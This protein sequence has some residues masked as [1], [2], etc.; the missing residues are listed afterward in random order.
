MTG[1]VFSQ[2]RQAVS[3]GPEVSGSTDGVVN[4]CYLTIKDFL[5]VPADGVNG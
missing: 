4:R 1:R 3:A 2:L 5:T